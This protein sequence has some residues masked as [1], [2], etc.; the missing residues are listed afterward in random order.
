MVLRFVVSKRRRLRIE[1]CSG[2]FFCSVGITNS[3]AVDTHAR[4][5]T[6]SVSRL[7]LGKVRADPLLEP[8][9]RT[10]TAAINCFKQFQGG[11]S[12]ASL[13]STLAGFSSREEELL[14]PVP[15]SDVFLLA[16][17][18]DPLDGREVTEEE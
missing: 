12:V 1:E 11:Q 18:P 4:P 13:A 9:Q 16:G 5:P 14:N 3:T 15:T 8:N 6:P 17:L 2:C 10:Y 7:C